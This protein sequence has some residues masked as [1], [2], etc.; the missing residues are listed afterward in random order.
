MEEL[1]RESFTEDGWFK[2]GDIGQVGDVGS[3]HDMN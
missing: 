3:S 1:T 2:T